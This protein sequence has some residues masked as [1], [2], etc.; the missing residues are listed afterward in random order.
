MDKGAVFNT[1][2]KLKFML[3]YIQK[4]NEEVFIKAEQEWFKLDEDKLK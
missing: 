2:I 1:I 3:D 4:N